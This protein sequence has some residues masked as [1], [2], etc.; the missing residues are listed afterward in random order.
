MS[1]RRPVVKPMLNVAKIYQEA[2][3]YKNRK[4]LVKEELSR[5]VELSN[6]PCKW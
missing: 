5:Y 1:L 4:I 6:M 3:Y 2:A